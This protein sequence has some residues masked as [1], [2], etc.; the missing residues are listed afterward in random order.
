[1]INSNSVLIPYIMEI[2]KILTWKFMKS[3]RLSVHKNP[4]N[5]LLTK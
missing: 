5:Q 3:Y 2:Y 4:F 1:M